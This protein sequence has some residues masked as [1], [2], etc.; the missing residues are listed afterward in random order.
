MTDITVLSLD[1]AK[2]QDRSAFV[3]LGRR[4]SAQVPHFVPQMRSEQIELVHPDKNPFFQHADVQLFIAQRGGKPVGRISAHIDHL[5][6]TIP[7]E[8]GMGPGTGMFGYF[9]ADDAEVAKALLAKAEEWLKAK[10]MTRVLAPLSMSVWEEP[11]L[12]VKGHD[13]APT[14]MMGHDDARYQAWIEGL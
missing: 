13:H 3:D 9:D 2:S 11:G 14:V 10:G 8:Q 12:L 7:P 6:L 1:A 5:A 4:F